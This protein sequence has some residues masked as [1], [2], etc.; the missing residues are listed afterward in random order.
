MKN[1]ELRKAKRILSLVA[2]DPDHGARGAWEDQD[3][4]AGTVLAELARLE[5]E[6]K[7]LRK[8]PEQ[9]SKE[10]PK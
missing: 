6:N 2:A 10:G 8:E 3:A 5:T 9:Q 1:M 4:A 7:R